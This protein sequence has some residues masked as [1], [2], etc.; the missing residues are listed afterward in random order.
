VKE[1]H[2]NRELKQ[3]TTTTQRE[4]NGWGSK[5]EMEWMGKHEGN[6]KDEEMRIWNEWGNKKVNRMDGGRKR[7]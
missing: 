7:E 2:V 6:V 5:K 4:W 3:T 1:K